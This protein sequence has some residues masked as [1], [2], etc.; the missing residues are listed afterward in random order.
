M[1]LQKAMNSFLLSIPELYQKSSLLHIDRN[2]QIIIGYSFENAIADSVE[3][4]RE[5]DA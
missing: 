1:F 2:I 5:D 4:R 3:R